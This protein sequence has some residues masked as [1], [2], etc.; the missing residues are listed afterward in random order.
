METAVLKCPKCGFEQELEIPESSCLQ[1][2]KCE[3]CGELISA[4][5]GE[6]CVI[7]AFSNKKCGHPV[8]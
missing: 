6:C 1:F 8:K 7:C 2:F 3:N 4:P 5:N